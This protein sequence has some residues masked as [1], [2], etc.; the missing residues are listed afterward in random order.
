MWV[1]AWSV[2]EL[3]ERGQLLS[4][5]RPG[6]RRHEKIRGRPFW[7]RAT[8]G[9]QAKMKHGRARHWAIWES[10]RADEQRRE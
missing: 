2:C 1:V 3:R 8:T 4:D 7:R 9:G 6:M 10:G 5:S